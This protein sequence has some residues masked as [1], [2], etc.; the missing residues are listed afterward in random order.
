MSW[1]VENII[2]DSTAIRDDVYY[3]AD[4]RLFLDLELDDYLSLLTVEDKIKELYDKKILS[5]LDLKI[6]HGLSEGKTYQQLAKELKLYRTTVRNMFR[7]IC[8]KIAFSLGGEFT[9]EGLIQSLTK[10]LNLNDEQINSLRE[11]IERRGR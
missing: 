3:E 4:N 2:L 7:N 1:L 6:L 11:F 5:N 10:K 8:E 9:N